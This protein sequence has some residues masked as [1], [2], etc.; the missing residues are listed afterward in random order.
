MTDDIA[1][2]ALPG[3]RMQ[4]VAEGHGALWKSTYGSSVGAE[5][6]GTFS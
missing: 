6:S 3:G 4:R 5:M 1:Q 2:E